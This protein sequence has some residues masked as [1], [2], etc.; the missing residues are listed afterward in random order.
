MHAIR[1]HRLNARLQSYHSHDAL[2]ASFLARLP[3]H[4]GFPG[5]SDQRAAQWAPPVVQCRLPQATAWRQMSQRCRGTGSQ[6]WCPAP[7]HI[8]TLSAGLRQA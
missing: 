6:G 5:V 1:P 4:R 3:L 7:S 2:Q 8:V